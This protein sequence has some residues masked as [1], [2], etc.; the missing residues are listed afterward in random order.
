VEL[1]DVEFSITSLPSRSDSSRYDENN[2]DDSISGVAELGNCSGSC[3]NLFWINYVTCKVHHD[4][5][6]LQ[7]YLSEWP[8]TILRQSKVL[9]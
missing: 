5:T 4:D 6:A 8:N 3:H 9:L 1:I 7:M 2:G